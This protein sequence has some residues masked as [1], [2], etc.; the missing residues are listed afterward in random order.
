M[1]TEKT[2][3]IHINDDYA[4]DLKNISITGPGS[5]TELWGKE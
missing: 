1:R 4:K 2:V 5:E 3:Q